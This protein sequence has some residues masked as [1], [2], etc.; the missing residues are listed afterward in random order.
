MALPVWPL[1]AQTAPLQ[2]AAATSLQDV[3]PA[4]VQAFARE[5]KVPPPAVVT[6]ASGALV[7]A[8]GQ[9][10][11]RAAA[12]VLLCDDAE[13]IARGVE[14]RLL[15]PDPVRNFASHGLVLVV[16]AGS[17]LPVRR[18]TD[19][20]NADVQRIALGRPA[21][22]PVGRF[23]RQAIDAARLW[24]S[25]QRKVVQADSARDV[26]RRVLEGE[27]DAAIVFA[28]DAQSAG[29]ALRV[30]EPLLNHSAIRLTAAVAVAAAQP[31]LAADFVLFLRS[32]AAT[33]LMVKAG[34][35]PP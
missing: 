26:L 18:L 33:D 27:A 22:V 3:M 28:S 19:L 13:T 10:G 35:G 32:P 24:P 5:R 6:G 2:V 17:R 4:L 1:W 20:A 31:D 15:R 8:L 23:A 34:F 16:P 7:E 9:R 29:P 12:D 14:R 30:V 11:A 25:V 21:S